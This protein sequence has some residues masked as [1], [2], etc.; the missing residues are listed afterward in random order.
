MCLV[1]GSFCAL[2]EIELDI[3]SSTWTSNFSTTVIK[4]CFN[5]Y[6]LNKTVSLKAGWGGCR[7]NGKVL[8]RMN[9]GRLCV[10]VYVP[11]LL[12]LWAHRQLTGNWPLSALTEWFPSGTT[13]QQQACQQPSHTFLS[14]VDAAS[15]ASLGGCHP[16]LPHSC[17]RHLNQH[18][19]EGD[20]ER[21]MDSWK[22]AWC[23]WELY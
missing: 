2:S 13:C 6:T 7:V 21:N 5:S 18:R 23:E 1:P 16:V 15:S 8:R 10:L 14:R 22:G 4:H 17:P 12:P 19:S 20:R 3:I 11:Q 9:T